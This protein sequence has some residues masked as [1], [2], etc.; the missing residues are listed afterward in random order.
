[1]VAPPTGRVEGVDN[2]QLASLTMSLRETLER[3]SSNPPPGNEEE[4]KFRI[5]API[6]AELG[7]DPFGTEVR[8]EYPAGGKI[9]SIRERVVRLLE[10]LGHRESDLVYLYG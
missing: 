8:W 1:M 3:I 6:L 10:A 9:R 2:G 5:L 4:A 7:W